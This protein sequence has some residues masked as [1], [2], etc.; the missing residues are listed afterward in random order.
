MVVERRG[1]VIAGRGLFA[2]EGIAR[3]ERVDVDAELLNHSCDPT[4]AWSADGA[5]LEA[6][7]DLSAGEELTV[8]YATSS[9]DPDMLVRC[10]CE[11]YRCRQMVTGD[12]WQIPQVQRRYA[13]HFAP[14]VQSLVDRTLGQPHSSS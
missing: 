14:S 6:F 12:D 13:G 9:A 5:G 7:R 2:T 1:S 3:G 11:T 10:H 8:D 4:L